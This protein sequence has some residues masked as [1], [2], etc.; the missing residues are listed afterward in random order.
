MDLSLITMPGVV[1]WLQASAR[2]PLPQAGALS[3]RQGWQTWRSP[4]GEERIRTGKYEVNQ[5]KEQNM[6][7]EQGNMVG[8]NQI[9]E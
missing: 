6:V 9:G 7:G 2:P 8:G 5:T 4:P 3:V 1:P